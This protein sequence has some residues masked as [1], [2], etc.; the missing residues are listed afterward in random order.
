MY[1]N[2]LTQEKGLQHNLGQLWEKEESFIPW[3]GLFLASLQ[4]FMT[5]NT[6]TTIKTHKH[7]ISPYSVIPRSNL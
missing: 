4:S 3:A 6:F 5:L 1:I 7:L 2:E